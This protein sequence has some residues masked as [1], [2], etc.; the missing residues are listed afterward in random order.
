[1][2][3]NNKLEIR[4]REDPWKDNII[5]AITDLNSKLDCLIELI[6]EVSIQ[7]VADAHKIEGDKKTS[8]NH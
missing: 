4:E 3:E 8:E 2:N 6:H 1:M 7:L 5:Q